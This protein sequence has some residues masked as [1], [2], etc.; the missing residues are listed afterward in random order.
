MQAVRPV[1]HLPQHAAALSELLQQLPEGTS[2]GDEE[3]IR[4][5]GEA[6]EERLSV[7]PGRAG[8]ER[9]E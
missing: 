8:E 4:Q 7:P 3:Q 1:L 2:G 5:S 9:K 6:D